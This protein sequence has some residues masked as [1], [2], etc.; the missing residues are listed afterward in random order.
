MNVTK[1]VRLKLVLLNLGFFEWVCLGHR[2]DRMGNRIPPC[3]T[4]GLIRR[5]T[6]NVHHRQ[7]IMRSL[8]SYQRCEGRRILK[9]HSGIHRFFHKRNLLTRSHLYIHRCCLQQLLP[10]QL[11]MNS[12][13]W[14][15]CTRRCCLILRRQT[16]NFSRRICIRLWR[17][18]G[19]IH[20][21]RR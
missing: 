6:L 9:V 21:W 20:P 17:Y 15:S 16:I 14:I 13:R 11:W 2:M 1:R 4:S 7:W 8:D 12:H 5:V 10:L 18:R 3:L 19:R